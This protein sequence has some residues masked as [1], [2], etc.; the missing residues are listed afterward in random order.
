MANHTIA[1][2]QKTPKNKPT[3]CGI[4]SLEE[5]GRVWVQTKTAF[6]PYKATLVTANNDIIMSNCVEFLK[7]LAR[8]AK[9]SQISY[10]YTEDDDVVAEYSDLLVGSTS[11]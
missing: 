5:D 10:Y 1:L 8:Q 11:L 2:F 4:F 9:L 3:V 6:R 7:E